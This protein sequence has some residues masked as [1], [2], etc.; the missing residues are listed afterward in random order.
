MASPELLLQMT[1]VSYSLLTTNR[2]EKNLLQQCSNLYHEVFDAPME[3]DVIVVAHLAQVNEVLTGA[4]CQVTVK[5][6]VDVAQVGVEPQVALLGG[7][8]GTC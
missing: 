5:F 7:V 1:A 2:I 4:W 3:D 6:N 8:P